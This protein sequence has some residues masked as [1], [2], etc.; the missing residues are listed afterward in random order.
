MAWLGAGAFVMGVGIWCMHF[1]G[2]IAFRLPV[3]VRYDFGITF[4]SIF[5]AIIASGVAIFI[6]SHASVSLARVSLASLAMAGGI[7][8]MHYAG[9]AA[10][11]TSARMAYD[12][13]LFILSLVVAFAL[14]IVALSMKFILRKSGTF[15]EI[16][17]S[18]SMGTAVAGMH[19]TGMGAARFFLVGDAPMAAGASDSLRQILILIPGPLLLLAGMII[20]VIVSRRMQRAAEAMRDLIESAPDAIVSVDQNGRICVFNRQAEVIFGR[21]RGEALGLPLEILVPERFR[22][23][24]V[25]HRAGYSNEPGRRPMGVGM[26]LWGLRKNGKEF[27][28]DISLSSSKTESETFVTSIIRDL[29]EKNRMAKALRDSEA[30]LLHSQKMEAL[31]RLAG[32]IAHDFNNNLT[33]IIGLCD[34]LAKQFPPGSSG[35]DDIAEIKAAGERSAAL[36]RQ[37]LSFSRQAPTVLGICDANELLAVNRNILA[38]MLGSHIRIKAT[39]CPSLLPI[40]ADPGQFSQVLMNLAVNARDAMPQGGDIGIESFMAGA[41]AEITFKD[42]GSGMEKPVLSRLFEPFFTTKEQGRG[43]GLGLSIIHGIVTGSG[44]TIEVESEPGHGTLFRLRFPLAEGKIE[45]LGGSVAPEK[46]ESKG[47]LILLVEDD[48]NVMKVTIRQLQNCGYRILAASNAEEAMALFRQRAPEIA[49]VITDVNMP[50]TNGMVLAQQLRTVRAETRVLFIS[51]YG[52]DILASSGRPENSE[53]LAKPFS[54]DVLTAKV[55][56]MLAAGSA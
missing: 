37:L 2:M 14:A 50:K 22:K 32:G 55:S 41:F 44:G 7:G 26:E 48:P 38:R 31:G 23:T 53:F 52:L 54:S 42:S 13:A 18:I 56:E 29:T 3:P 11:I 40:R 45:A 39:L 4:G 9:M 10:M 25:Q 24:H 46:Q 30:K 8:T 12:P 16:A 1:V 6:I 28:V 49:L 34:L 27:P 36:T 19:Y 47:G 15:W 5:P 35:G 20:G 51:G 21:D 43:T 17:I 33:S